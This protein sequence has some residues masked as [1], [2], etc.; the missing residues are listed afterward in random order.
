MIVMEL[1]GGDRFCL[2]NT[3]DDVS[4]WKDDDIKVSIITIRF[5]ITIKYKMY[6]VHAS[7]MEV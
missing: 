6:T 4:V 7:A 2:M 1:L 5:G 3:V